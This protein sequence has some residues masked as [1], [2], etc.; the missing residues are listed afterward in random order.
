M[1]YSLF[2]FYYQNS[3]KPIMAHQKV[4]WLVLEECFS[5]VLILPKKQLTTILELVLNVFLS[6]LQDMDDKTIKTVAEKGFKMIFSNYDTMYL[7]CGFGNYVGSGNNWCS[8]FKRKWLE[9]AI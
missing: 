2:L 3:I 5:K 8:P 6:F 1:N 7:D 9:I 4:S